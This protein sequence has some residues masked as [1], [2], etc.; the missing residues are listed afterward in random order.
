MLLDEQA[1]GRVAAPRATGPSESSTRAGTAPLPP[2]RVAE[3]PGP[4]DH[5]VAQARYQTPLRYP[6]AK[7]GLTPVIKDLLGAAVGRRKIPKI[8]LFVEPF[9]G[10]AATSLRLVSAGYVDRI[11]LADADPLVASLW[12]VAAADTEALV[13]RMIDEHQ[14]FVVKGGGVALGRW[15]YWRSWGPRP[16]Q[17]TK[18]QQADLAMK[19]LFLNRTTFSGILHGRA[20]PIGGRAQMSAYDIGCRFNTEN[21][22]E[23]IRFVGY[24]YDQGR[25]LDVWCKDWQA[26][27]GDIAEWYPHLI[28]DKVIAYLDP[29]YIEKSERLYTRSFDPAGGYSSRQSPDVE[30]LNGLSHLKL[31]AYLR[32][33]MRF[34]WILSY[35]Q[36]P[37]LLSDPALYASNRMNPSPLDRE[38]LG[39]KAWR[40]HK[41]VIDV[42]YTASARGHGRRQAEELLLTTVPMDADF[43]T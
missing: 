43:L 22:T 21:L 20:G 4:V 36:V 10:G 42:R 26:T 31:S 34:R 37:Q 8:G 17:S 11:L 27:L 5:P 30:W 39:I 13:D 35:D 24:L 12:Q 16:G 14:R 41:R 32:T 6:G 23:R 33:Q 3:V 2:S 1:A 18:S 25:I 15:D 7:A 28:P 19:C 9:A 29:P 40:I 38:L